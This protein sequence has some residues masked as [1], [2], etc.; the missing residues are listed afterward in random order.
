MGIG[1]RSWVAVLGAVLLA[2]G[3]G[4]WSQTPSQDEERAPDTA[5]CGYRLMTER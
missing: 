2:A 4:A 5:I 1:S 3:H